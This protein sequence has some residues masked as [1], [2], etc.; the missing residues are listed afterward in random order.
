VSAQQSEKIETIILLPTLVC[1]WCKNVIKAGAL[2][3]SHGIC[4]PCQVRHFPTPKPL[5]A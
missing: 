3:R 5:A 1:A 4:R 2:K